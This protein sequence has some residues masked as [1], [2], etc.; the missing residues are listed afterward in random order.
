MSLELARIAKNHKNNQ[1]E[2]TQTEIKFVTAKEIERDL[3]K[4]LHFLHR[5]SHNIRQTKFL[6]KNMALAIS[7]FTLPSISSDV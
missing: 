1:R 4:N 7:D 3:K 6:L 2:Q 5:L